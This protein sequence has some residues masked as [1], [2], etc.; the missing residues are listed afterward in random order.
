MDYQSSNDVE[1]EIIFAPI[2]VK[3]FGQD[4]DWKSC[5]AVSQ[6]QSTNLYEPIVK[7]MIQKECVRI[8]DPYGFPDQTQEKYLEAF[9]RYKEKY[10]LYVQAGIWKSKE[11]QEDSQLFFHSQSIRRYL[12]EI[13]S[14][15]SSIIRNNL[16]VSA[17]IWND[18]LTNSSVARVF[19]EWWMLT[20]AGRTRDTLMLMNSKEPRKEMQKLIDEMR[21]RNDDVLSYLTI[22]VPQ[23][24]NSTTNPKDI[25][26]RAISRFIL[27]MG[28][29]DGI[30]EREGLTKNFVGEF[31]YE[32]YLNRIITD[33]TTYASGLLFPTPEDTIERL[34]ERADLL[35]NDIKLRN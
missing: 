22:Q 20:C 16:N 31:N 34:D 35:Y 23:I 28:I 32:N 29:V 26:E 18:I 24:Y 4:L 17:S 15:F 9:A 30:L 27:D 14:Q 5:L 19:F 1:N 10:Q 2:I 8:F 25:M 13:R 21:V 12:S 11:I 3:D 6:N 33:S 7:S